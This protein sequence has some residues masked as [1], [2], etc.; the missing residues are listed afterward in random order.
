MVPNC[1][2]GSWAVGGASNDSRES[3]NTPQ[4]T[5]D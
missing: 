5:A 4:D 1:P 2:G 3:S